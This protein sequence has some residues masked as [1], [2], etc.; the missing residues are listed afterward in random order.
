M[1]NRY[2]V[3]DGRFGSD[4]TRKDLLMKGLIFYRYIMKIDKNKYIHTQ[5]RHCEIINNEYKKWAFENAQII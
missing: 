1:K 5:K 2:E 4:F 3:I